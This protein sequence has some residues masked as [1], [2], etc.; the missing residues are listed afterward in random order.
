MLSGGSSGLGEA[1]SKDWC[2]RG[3][4]SLVRLVR[5]RFYETCDRL[6]LDC[7]SLTDFLLPSPRGP[8]VQMVPTRDGYVCACTEDGSCASA[9]VSAEMMQVSSGCLLSIGLPDNSISV[10]NQPCHPIRATIFAT[11]LGDSEQRIRHM[12]GT[13]HQPSLPP[14]PEIRSEGRMTTPEKTS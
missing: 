8:P 5:L 14:D 2:A 3:H 7:R 4:M 11:R 10:M 13:R 6:G 12:E 9:A 1:Q